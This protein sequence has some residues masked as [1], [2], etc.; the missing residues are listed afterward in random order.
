MA[1]DEPEVTNDDRKRMLDRLLIEALTDL[2]AQETMV[3][4]AKLRQ[5]VVEAG[6]QQGLDV[7]AH[8]AAL[9]RPFSKV[10]GPA[11]VRR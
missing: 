3:P 2:R 7:A 6:L 8:L 4:G 10:L 5:Q 9:D 11:D 1:C